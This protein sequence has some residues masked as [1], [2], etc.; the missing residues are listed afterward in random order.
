[1]MK[2]GAI[3]LMGLPGAGKGTQ[4]FRLAKRFPNFVHFDTG[5]EIYR[6]VTDPA[7][8]EDPAVQKQ[9]AIYFAGKLN[10]PTWVAGLV[11]ER[12]RH[13]SKEGKGIILS[14]SPRTLR[15]ARTIA[16][17]L[18]KEYGRERILVLVLEISEEEARRRSLK[19]I[20]CANPTCRY[21]TTRDSAGQPCPECGQIIPQ[22]NDLKETWKISRLETRLAEFQERTLPALEF[23]RHR[24]PTVVIDGSRREEEVFAEIRTAIETHLR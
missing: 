16:P 13:Y 12:L 6:R 8:A 18:V 24:F 17:Q 4:A 14:G 23:L 10:T 20:V 11:V 7:F 5:G 1:M 22:A 15:E 21:P 3:L 2:P 9:R 19:R